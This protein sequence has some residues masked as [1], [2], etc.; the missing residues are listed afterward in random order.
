MQNF[1][2]HLDL[3]QRLFDNKKLFEQLK[4]G[5][6]RVIKW[7]NQIPVLLF[8]NNKHRKPPKNSFFKYTNKR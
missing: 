4:S 3:E 6:N 5:F 8:E 2:I 1:I 7:N